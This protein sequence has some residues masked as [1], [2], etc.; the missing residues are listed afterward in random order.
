MIHPF[1]AV[2]LA[3]GLLLAAGPWE[4]AADAPADGLR[5]QGIDFRD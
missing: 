3:A 4:A 5:S 2:R 1:I